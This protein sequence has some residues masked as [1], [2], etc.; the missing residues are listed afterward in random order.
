MIENDCFP[1]KSTTQ[2]LIKRKQSLKICR[3]DLLEDLA[4]DDIMVKNLRVRK[5]TFSDKMIT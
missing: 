5:S 4:E 3:R 2:H 1:S